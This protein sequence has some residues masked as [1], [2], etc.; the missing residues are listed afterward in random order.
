[1]YFTLPKLIL[2]TLPYDSYST[3]VH[4]NAAKYVC[5]C[6]PTKS[7]SDTK[8]SVPV[9]KWWEIFPVFSVSFKCVNSTYTHFTLSVPYC[10]V[11]SCR[12]NR[13]GIVTKIPSLSLNGFE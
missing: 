6:K 7:T 11:I 13:N 5:V 1:M 8:R 10:V 3:Y 9:D 4:K 2:V 12:T